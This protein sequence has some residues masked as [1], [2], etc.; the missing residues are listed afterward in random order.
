MTQVVRLMS[1]YNA[2]WPL[3]H[4]GETSREDWPQVSDALARELEHWNASWH[5][6][7]RHGW[8]DEQARRRYVD[9]AGPLA[10]RVRAEL[11][12]DWVVEVGPLG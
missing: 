5:H 9:A 10:E 3:W 6:D 8:S 7:H 4:R 2:D 11:G 12:P 1:D